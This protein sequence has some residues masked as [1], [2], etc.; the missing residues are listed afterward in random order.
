MTSRK[1]SPR[2]SGWQR[3]MVSS[4]SQFELSILGAME[5]LNMRNIENR[6]SALEKQ[7]G[8]GKTII[9][10]RDEDDAV[11][12]KCLAEAE[13]KRGPYDKIMVVGWQRS[14]PRDQTG[15]GL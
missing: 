15:A 2:L 9:V 12:E 5:E 8:T 4:S 11:Y 13:A 10:W 7:R 6:L 1:K 3:P 14:L